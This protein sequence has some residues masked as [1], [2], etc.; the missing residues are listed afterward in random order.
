MVDIYVWVI[1]TVYQYSF[2]PLLTPSINYLLLVLTL[3]LTF[4]I[5]VVIVSHSPCYKG[6]VGYICGT[7]KFLSLFS[8]QAF[9]VDGRSTQ[10]AERLSICSSAHIFSP[11]RKNAPRFSQSDSEQ[12]SSEVRSILRLQ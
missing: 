4:L 11:V 1:S 5:Q 6:M 9:F 10:Y 3:L 7:P 12:P 2:L 8:V